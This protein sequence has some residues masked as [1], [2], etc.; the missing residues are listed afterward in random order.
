MAGDDLEGG[1]TGF[2]KSVEN[3]AKSLFNSTTSSISRA[4][5][6]ATGMGGMAST[7]FMPSQK[8]WAYFAG[9]LCSGIFF[10]SLA[11]FV[12]LPMLVIAPAKFATSFTLGCVC[13]M[14]SFFALR[15]WKQQLVHMTAKERLPFT[16][17]YL[18]SIFGTLYASL[19]LHSYLL[20]ITFSGVQIFAL[21]YYVSSYFPGGSAGMKM[22]L[23]SCS[24]GVFS[25][26]SSMF[27]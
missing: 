1:T 20:S 23:S 24:S 13:V 18:G 5:S 21:L 26:F 7:Q 14:A 12:M 10:L 25:L 17:A 22:M 27:R 15:G 16:G 11:I 4:A 9:F 6:A 19:W 3:T 2:T 8:Q